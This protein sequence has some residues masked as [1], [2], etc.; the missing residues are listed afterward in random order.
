MES[1]NYPRNLYR[2]GEGL[3]GLYMMPTVQHFINSI[4]MCDVLS[5]KTIYQPGTLRKV[6]N[7]III[8]NATFP[9]V[10]DCV[11]S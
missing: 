1:S 11:Y 4:P 2:C 6:M 9:G 10:R 3:K 5:S 7:Y 8:F